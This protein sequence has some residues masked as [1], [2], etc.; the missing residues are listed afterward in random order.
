MDE[1][2]SMVRLLKAQKDS[3]K[4]LE[5]AALDA[6]SEGKVSLVK[7]LLEAKVDPNATDDRRIS[8]LHRAAA[9]SDPELSK[10]SAHII[11]LLAESGAVIRRSA[12]HVA[13]NPL[14]VSALVEL[15]ADVDA[16]STDGS[17][18][19]ALAISSGRDEVAIELIR[20]NAKVDS[21]L[22][23]RCKNPDVARELLRAN[24]DPN[25]KD[26]FGATPLQYAVERGDR[27]LARVLL[28]YRA[29]PGVVSGRAPAVVSSSASSNS[30]DVGPGNFLKTL[31]A[32][33]LSVLNAE[34]LLSL[35]NAVSDFLTRVKISR[36]SAQSCCVICRSSPKRVVLLPCRHMCI[37]DACTPPCVCPIC[38]CA[39]ESSIS[40]FT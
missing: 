22:L 9:I 4:L 7:A 21:S 12:L 1:I 29:D 5:A 32:V 6:C 37:C 13:G 35:E 40:V 28:E 10:A 25:V 20:L 30:G 23:F 38:R 31:A 18:P 14:A 34:D 19:L 36:S 33:N 24:A 11:K 3:A 16:K 2:D 39:V 15:K 17:T 27:A 8:M 26:M